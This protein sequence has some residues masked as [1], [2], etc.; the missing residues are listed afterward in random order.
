M[1]SSP[2]VNAAAL[3]QNEE[4]DTPASTQPAGAA[5][6]ARAG[7]TP[8]RRTA[9]HAEIARELTARPYV[10]GTVSTY[11]AAYVVA[12]IARRIRE[13]S[14]RYHVYGPA[15]SF[16]TRAT[17]VEDG[18]RLEARYVRGIARPLRGLIH[19]T[20]DTR[21]APAGLGQ[22]W[23]DAVPV[24]SSPTGPNG[25]PMTAPAS[26]LPHDPYITAVCE[27]LDKAGL[28]V[29][30]GRTD[31]C[32]TRG[33]Y[34]YL[35]AVIELDMLATGLQ[36]EWPHGLLLIWEWHSGREADLG[37]PERGPQWSFAELNGDGSN[38]YPTGL[39]V[40]GY[41]SPAAVVD[42]ARKVISQEIQ[43][44]SPNGLGQWRGWDGGI[45]GDSWGQADELESA[46]AAWD[47]QE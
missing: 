4:K 11:P 29:K 38:H 1:P 36:Q 16:E 44:G 14:G 33:T 2:G 23:P 42:A 32:E 19:G 46:A 31:D 17:P 3:A 24:L 21:P 45:I 6:T 26:A 5:S 20:P 8:G 40:Y 39:P 30:D 10:W 34:C 35:N 43:P 13:A 9:N 41:A 27:A 7:S 37:E 22:V 15:G 18:T 12:Q 28:E 25:T 47:A